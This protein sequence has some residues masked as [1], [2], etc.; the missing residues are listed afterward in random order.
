MKS[1]VNIHLDS[2]IVITDKSF[3]D[4]EFSIMLK[5]AEI[6]PVYQKKDH[7]DNWRKQINN[8]KEVCVLL[9]IYQKH[10]IQLIINLAVDSRQSWCNFKTQ[11]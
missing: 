6:F 3:R 8:S 4:G 5:V 9:W 10:L 11:A 7:L 2:L 1:S